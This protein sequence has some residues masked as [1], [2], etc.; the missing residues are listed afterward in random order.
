MTTLNEFIESEARIMA[1]AEGV[2][3]ST[4]D[5]QS[6]HELRAY[7]R[8]N[9]ARAMGR[10]VGY[11]DYHAAIMDRLPHVTRV[12]GA[13]LASNTYETVA[14]LTEPR[15]VAV[16]IDGLSIALMEHARRLDLTPDELREQVLP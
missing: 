6:C 16:V 15:D 10:Y 8:N 7:W 12:L 4:Y 1:L 11:H 2:E 5:S 13:V 3:A 9:A 14:D